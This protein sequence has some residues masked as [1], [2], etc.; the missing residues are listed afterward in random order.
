[1]PNRVDVTLA[2]S[3]RDLSFLTYAMGFIEAVKG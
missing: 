3:A 2:M 1:M